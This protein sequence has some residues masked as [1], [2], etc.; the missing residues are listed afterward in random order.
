MSNSWAQRPFIFA[1][2]SHYSA[3]SPSSPGLY[4][5]KKQTVE[6]QAQGPFQREKC[7]QFPKGT[8]EKML[9]E[10]GRL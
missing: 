5:V 9:K 2:L 10:T 3:T 1:D 4:S 8:L 6:N 7:S